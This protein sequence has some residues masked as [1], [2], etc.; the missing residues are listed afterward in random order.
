VYEAAVYSNVPK[1]F[2]L[3]K[4]RINREQSEAILEPN[5]R[6][7]ESKLFSNTVAFELTKKYKKNHTHIKGTHQEKFLNLAYYMIKV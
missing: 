2:A 4:F 6:R 5:L 3:S 1:C 7:L